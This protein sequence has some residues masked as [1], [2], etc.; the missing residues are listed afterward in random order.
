MTSRT[1][2]AESHGFVITEDIYEGGSLRYPKNSEP[3][4]DLWRFNSK[5][6]RDAFVDEDNSHNAITA[7][8]A[9]REHRERFA[10]LKALSTNVLHLHN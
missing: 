4:T 10:Y 6:D 1:Y 9:R 8:D 7:A 5:A 3:Y 2:Y